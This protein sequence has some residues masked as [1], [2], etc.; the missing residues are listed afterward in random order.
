M[1]SERLRYLDQASIRLWRAPG[2][3]TVRGEVLGELCL[4]H[5]RLRR[6]APLS[7]PEGYLSLED[8]NGKEVGILRGL[9]G[10]DEASRSIALEELDRR[11][12]TPIIRAIRH[13]EQEGG[14]WTFDVDTQRGSARFYVRNWRDSAH[15]IKA[16]RWQIRSVDGQRYEIEN[17]AQLDARSQ[18]LLELVF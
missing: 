14:I 12:F 18:Q 6:A 8:G 16:G 10:L 11:Y 15:E 1:A 7:S 5:A 3:T 17:L 9:D 4:L 2:S 13:L